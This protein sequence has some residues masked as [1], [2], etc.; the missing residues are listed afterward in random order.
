MAAPP[1]ALLLLAVYLRRKD[2][3]CCQREGVPRLDGAVKKPH[4]DP[5]AGQGVR[6]HGHHQDRTQGTE[7]TDQAVAQDCGSSPRGRN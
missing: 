7:E 3:T 1:A 2:F 5:S 6:G 4:E